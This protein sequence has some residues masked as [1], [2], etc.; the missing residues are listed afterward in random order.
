MSLPWLCEEAKGRALPQHCRQSLFESTGHL[1]LHINQAMHME[2]YGSRSLAA[3]HHSAA[4]SGMP[5]NTKLVHLLWCHLQYAKVHGLS[6]GMQKHDWDHVGNIC[7]IYLSMRFYSK[8]RCLLNLLLIILNPF[9]KPC[10]DFINFIICYLKLKADVK[11]ADKV[12]EVSIIFWVLKKLEIVAAA[13]LGQDI[14][15]K[16]T[17]SQQS[18]GSCGSQCW[19]LEFHMQRVS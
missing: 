9:N 4:P 2:I 18:I 12:D 19:A 1:W 5:N 13:E 14:V 8:N 3:G 17:T 16:R 6:L 15:S 10:S 11:Q 7:C